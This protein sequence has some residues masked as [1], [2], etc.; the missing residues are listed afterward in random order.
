MPR[1]PLLRIETRRAD[2]P[3]ELFRRIADLAEVPASEL[4][5]ERV[6]LLRRVAEG[7]GGLARRGAVAVGDDVGR[8]AGAVGAVLL[9]DVLDDFFALVPR[10]E[11]Q[12]DVGPLAAFLREEPL[13]EELHLHRIDGRDRERVADG[14]VGG[15]AP[16]LREDAVLHAEAHD[17]PHDQEVAGEIELLDHR[18]LLLDLRLG[19]RRQRPEACAGAVPG[20]LPQV[21]GRRLAGR[22]RVVRELVAE[23]RE[24]EV[25]PARELD[26]RVE[27][28]GQVRKQSGHLGRAPEVPL[29]LR[30]EEAARAVERRVVADAGEDVVELLV[31]LP[32]VAHAVGGKEREPQPP[33]DIHERLVAPLLLPE[34]MPLELDVEP[35][36]EDRAE[37]FEQRPRR[38][39]PAP[40]ERASDGRLVAA[41]RDVQ[42][43][44]VRG[45]LFERDRGLALRLAERAGGDETAEVL[46]SPS[47]S[48]RG[49]SVAV[50]R[51]PPASCFLPPRFLPPASSP[52]VTS[53]PTSALTPAA[54]AAFQNRGAP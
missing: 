13:E 41:R 32:R 9:V 6:D 37:P 23:V 8:H 3:G 25:E 30:G 24:S 53:A 43:L 29:A 28:F 33:R 54:F 31:L 35:S 18:E 11:V 1:A 51:L 17:V 20:D 45:D 14:A 48:R 22:Q 34:T 7:L 36:R 19:L 27:C 5:G 50:L 40:R 47:D 21:R 44:R 16:A 12:V 39:G 2:L 15:R 46:D 42:P 26:G 52:S 4:L 38:V 10:R 49:E